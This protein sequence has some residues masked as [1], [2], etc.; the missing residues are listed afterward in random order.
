MYRTSHDAPRLRAGRAAARTLLAGALAAGALLPRSVRAQG[1]TPDSL[2]A[3]YVPGSGTVYRIRGA[4]TPGRCAPGHTEFAWTA[5]AADGESA[6]STTGAATAAAAV[7]HG[8]LVGLADDDHPQYLLTQ[9]TRQS[10]N[11]FAVAGIVGQG[12]IP[13]SGGGT[14]MMWYPGKAAFRAGKVGGAHWDAA[15]VG[16]SSVAMG[17]DVTAR[18]ENSVALGMYAEATGYSAVALGRTTKATETSAFAAGYRSEATS[19][20]AVAIGQHALASGINAVALGLNARAGGDAATALGSGTI[21]SGYRSTAMGY[22]ASTNL[23]AGAFVYADN[24]S[25][26]QTLAKQDNHFV[27]RAQRFWLG[28]NSAVTATAGRFLETST[29]GYLSSGG[30]WTNSSDSARKH[31]F[32]A[33]DGEALLTSLAALPVR[34]W[35]YRAEGD[36]VRHLGPTAQAFRAAFQLGDTDRA[37]ATVDADGVSLAAAQALER[38]SREQAARLARLERENAELRAAFA[39]DVR[40]LRGRVAQLEGGRTGAAPT[41]ASTSH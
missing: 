23:K 40:A 33:V 1:T 22:E 36:T 38:R 11:G 27:V 18:G 8:T 29:G 17:H 31:R 30:T 10:P 3:C 32:E 20:F 9:G 25:Q 24:S 13:V 5:G 4:A 12:T 35:S 14:R 16:V 19:Q 15:N 26:T 7:D 21:A 28:N 34:R 2:H 6:R 37:I 41:A 39:R